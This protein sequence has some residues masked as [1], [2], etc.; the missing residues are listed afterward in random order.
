MF[1]KIA[2]CIVSVL[3]VVTLTGCAT[4]LVAG[5]GGAGTA[6]WLSGKMSETVNKPYAKTI[7]ASRKAL[8]S[9]KMPIT[10][11][12]EKADVTQLMS[13]YK[14]GSKTWIDIRPVTEKTT[15]IDVRVGM[16]GDKEGSEKILKAI[17]RR[18]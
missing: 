17:K 7:K 1:R 16:R 11:D 2:V 12:T 15:K 18:L 5:A 8:K 4:V 10:E 13:T 14:D 6:Y 3:L 9:L